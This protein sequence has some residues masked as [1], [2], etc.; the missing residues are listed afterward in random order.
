[1]TRMQIENYSISFKQ[2]VH[3]IDFVCGLDYL[4]I[5]F[6]KF[7]LDQWMNLVMYRKDIASWDTTWSV[8]HERKNSSTFVVPEYK[9][10]F[11][12]LMHDNIC[13]NCLS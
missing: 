8:Y 2:Y 5:S 13:A 4:P 3:A 6:V 9:I 7:L 10:L 1:M 12:E 11:C